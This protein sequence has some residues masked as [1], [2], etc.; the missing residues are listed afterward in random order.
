MVET[1]IPIYL[2]IGS[3]RCF[4]ASIEW[5]GWCRSGKTEDAAVDV[6][7]EIAPRYAQIARRAHK[8][9]P[10]IGP[11]RFE[12]VERVE[13]NATTDFGAPGKVPKAD[14]EDFDRNQANRLA[15]LLQA[16]WD[17]LD[18]VVAGA[19][20]ELRKGPRGGGRDRDGVYRHVLGA[21]SS[22]VRTI[23]LKLKEP[24]L[25][26]REAIDRMRA[27]ILERIVP[28]GG[29]PDKGWPIPYFVRRDAWHVLDHAWEI[30]DKSP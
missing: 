9:F 22:Y 7:A 19:P 17:F 13:G 6:L 26:D 10:K 15:D 4:A 24:E 1:R 25:G 3:K 18:E 11:E 14:Y 27:A 23:G 12:V 20:A 21:E 30:Q 28:G 29:V 16:S 2:E 5:P 8:R